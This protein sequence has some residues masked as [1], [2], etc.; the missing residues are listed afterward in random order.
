M[1]LDRQDAPLKNHISTLR[2]KTLIIVSITVTSLISVLYLTTSALLTQSYARLE[3]QNT[4]ENVERVLAAFSN[5]I[6]VLDA[7]NSDWASWDD[8]YTFVQ[9]SNQDFIDQN[10]TTEDSTLVNVNIM[11]FYNAAGKLVYGRVYDDASAQKKAL[12]LLSL[13]R[14]I[15]SNS[16]ILQH[17]T[18]TSG[19]IGVVVLPEEPIILTSRPILTSQKS[20]PM[21]GTLVMG[22]YLNSTTTQQL[23]ETT[24]LRLKF[25]RLNQQN[26]QQNQL[27][28][29]LWTVRA[30]L[31]TAQKKA[32]ILVQPQ[33]K[34]LVSGYALIDDITNRAALLVEVDL[35]RKIYQQGQQSLNYLA[36]LLIVVGVLSGTIAQLLL[37]KLIRFQHQLQEREARYRAVVTQT[38]EGILLVNAN[39][40]RLLEANHAC[41]QLLG[42]SN[43]KMLTL[44]LYDI[45]S[46]D[47]QSID[48]KIQDLLI[49]K[50]QLPPF[51]QKY[52]RQDQTLVDVEVSANLISYAKNVICVVIRDITERKITEA[53]LRESEQRLAWQ[54]SHD[55][56]TGLVNRREFE[57]QLEHALEEVKTKGCHHSLCYLDLD[58][59]K[60]VNDTCG[61]GVGDDLLRQVTDLLRSQIRSSDVL[62]RLGGDEFGLLLYHCPLESAE[63]TANAL[64]QRLRAFRFSWQDKIFNVGAS[65]GLVAL[66]TPGQTLSTVMSAADAACYVAKN[67]GRNRVHVY[68]TNDL[69]LTQQ[70]GEMQWVG[71][72]T[73]ALEENRFCLYYQSIVP[74]ALGQGE[75]EHYEVLLRLL[76]EQGSLVAPMAFIPAAERYNLM[77]LIDRWV[78]RTLFASQGSYYREAWHRSQTQD[79]RCLYTINLSGASI[80][81][82][83][84]VA[85]LHEQ[86]A[87]H[88]VPPQVICFEITETVAITNLNRAMQLMQEFKRLGCCFALDDF[89]SGMSSFS[90]LKSL[91]VDYLKID[92][93][94]I[95]NT[96]SDPTHLAMAEAINQIGHLMKIQTIAEFVENDE[97]LQHLRTIGVDYAQGYGIA[98]PR[99]LPSGQTASLISKKFLEAEGVL[100][101]IASCTDE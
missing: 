92:G 13:E 68:Q 28:A 82:N 95:R 76:D 18:L 12:L 20:G 44:T 77:H 34:N 80:N 45:V 66:D 32:Q 42:Y 30:L 73:Q 89:G 98:K 16:W 40:K 3:E 70:H 71:R 51:E 41:L 4:Q 1:R 60:I 23:A 69:E 63:K 46:D 100:M 38:S 97:T 47:R 48:R 2:Q 33:T 49:H 35:P 101:Q 8:T 75:S 72:I 54:A 81:D 17:Q 26:Q 25:Y 74:V 88:Q 64:C 90:Y 39:T 93:D 57:R 19:H 7:T 21:R 6:S 58:Q 24:Q 55:V 67:N 53:T 14:Y 27:P 11:L 79:F 99:P 78:I 36:A 5:N 85:F 84:F 29:R 83:Q 59:F 50:S 22:R 86:F 9:N 96:L 62:A 52:Y 37:E 87:L 10:L 65:I 94:F 31:Q 56:L 91:P 61:H 15:R 43:E